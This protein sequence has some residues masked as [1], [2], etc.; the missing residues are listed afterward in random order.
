[1]GTEG[2]GRLQVEEC[3]GGTAK[4]GWSQ[5]QT[6]HREVTHSQLKCGTSAVPLAIPAKPSRFSVL[7]H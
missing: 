1:M 4:G 5:A 2:Q 7:R 6:L 3:L